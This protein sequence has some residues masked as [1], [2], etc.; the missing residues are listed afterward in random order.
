MRAKEPLEDLAGERPAKGDDGDPALAGR[1]DQAGGGGG[2]EASGIHRTRFNHGEISGH[3]PIM[4]CGLRIS[5]CG[6]YNCTQGR[7]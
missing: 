2:G 6:L 1:R 7:Q 5:D 3:D 4:N